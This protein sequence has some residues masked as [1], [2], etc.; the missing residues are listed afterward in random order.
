VHVEEDDLGSSSDPTGNS[1]APLACCIIRL[2]VE[3]QDP[4]R[5]PEAKKKSGNKSI[6]NIR[7]D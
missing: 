2:M 6:P 7:I 3:R 4:D 1:G 5:N